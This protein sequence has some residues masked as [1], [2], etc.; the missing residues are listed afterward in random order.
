[1]SHRRGSI[2][3]PTV[4]L[5]AI[6][7]CKYNA[8][9]ERVNRV[10]EW[11]AACPPPPPQILCKLQCGVS[12]FKY[13]TN[14]DRQHGSILQCDFDHQ[15]CLYSSAD[16]VQL[17]PVFE[18]NKAFGLYRL[19]AKPFQLVWLVLWLIQKFYGSVVWWSVRVTYTMNKNWLESHSFCWCKEIP[20]TLSLTNICRSGNAITQNWQVLFVY[21]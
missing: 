8:C 14:S 15:F 13:C 1:M 20:T 6:P 21:N 12:A 4:Q 3:N 10:L 11:P 2:G 19:T 5:R 17:K 9:L 7:L 16:H 18:L